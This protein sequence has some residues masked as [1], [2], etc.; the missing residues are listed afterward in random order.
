MKKQINILLGLLLLGTT[1]YGE[2]LAIESVL[3]I[4]YGRNVT[5]SGVEED[6]FM[7]I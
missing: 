5:Q 6:L 4:T 1:V 3:D 2:E 7:D